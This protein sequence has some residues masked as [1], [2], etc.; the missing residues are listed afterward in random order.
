MEFWQ[1]FLRV[2]IS[3][4]IFA[5]LF[6]FLFIW[7]YALFVFLFFWQLKDSEK[8][9]QAYRATIASLTE[10][11]SDME[12]MQDDIDEIREILEANEDERQD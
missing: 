6:V 7:F 8:R 2:V 11:L 10:R 5:V 12:K 9:E 3:N 4:G 1:E